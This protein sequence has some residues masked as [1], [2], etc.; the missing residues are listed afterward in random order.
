MIE[1]ANERS[2]P[3]TSEICG[4]NWPRTTSMLSRAASSAK[5][6][7]ITLKLAVAA[8]VSA[9]SRVT[10]SVGRSRG[11]SSLP[12]AWPTTRTYSAWLCRSVPSAEVRVPMACA[13]DDSACATSVRVTSPTR[14]R[15]CVASSCLRNTCDVV[16]I[17]LDQSLVA[18]HVEIGLGD[19]LKHRGLDREGLRPGRLHRVDRLPGLGH[20]ATAG[21]DRLGHLEIEAVLIKGRIGAQLASS[22]AAVLPAV[23]PLRAPPSCPVKLTVGRQ[24]DSACG[25]CSSVARSRARCAS[26]CG[27]VL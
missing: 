22:R 7:E 1:G 11:S 27:L 2:R 18:N 19:R 9:S 14:K 26:S 12:G 13:S 10:G 20:G 3:P 6:A 8:R 25:T 15:S 17:D 21:I 16:A 23:N 24:P 5:L 4:S